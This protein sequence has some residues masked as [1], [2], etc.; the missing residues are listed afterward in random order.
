MISDS[1]AIKGTTPAEMDAEEAARKTP[2]FLR[3][4]VDWI[5]DKITWPV[6][7]FFTYNYE[8]I[9]RSLAWARKGWKHYDWESAYLY[10]V[11]AWK[12]KRIHAALLV[13][14]A[15]QEDENMEALKEAIAICERLFK[16]DYDDPYRKAHDEKWGE[17]VT[18]FTPAYFPNGEQS[19]SYWNSSRPNAVTEEQKAEEVADLRK[20]WEYE[21]RD[22]KLDIDR[23][24]EILKKHEPSWWD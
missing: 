23:L 19:G 20:I 9:S 15:I 10:D 22:R 11:M 3:P 17:M 2:K 14:N 1:K 12:M 16:A 18:W 4:L 8:R 6:Q 13:G 7:H 21:E 24:A 5:E